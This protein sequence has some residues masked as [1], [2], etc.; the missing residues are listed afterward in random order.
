MS[1][2]A[3]G[4]ILYLGAFELPDK[5]AAAHRVIAN[6]KIFRN[7][8]YKVVLVGVD[9]SG[10]EAEG[11]QRSPSDYFEFESWNVPYPRSIKSW[12]GYITNSSIVKELV[13]GYYKGQ[14]KAVIHYNHPAVS[15]WRSLSFCTRNNIKHIADITEWYDS[16]AGRLIW[17]VIK[18]IDTALRMRWVNFIEDGLITTSPF[19]TE[20]YKRQ[21]TK[22]ELPALYDCSD[23]L[24]VGCNEAGKSLKLIYPSSPIDLEMI[25]KD[26]TNLK[27]RLDVIVES[28]YNLY[29]EGV[30][31]VLDVYG[32]TRDEFEQV[33]PSLKS[34]LEQLEGVVFFHGKI[35]NSLIRKKI[36]KADFMVFIRDDN[37]V[38]RAGF[39]GKLGE[40]ISLGTPVLTTKLPNLKSFEK[41]E[42]IRMS[43]RGSEVEMLREASKMSPNE[44]VELKR[45]CYESALFDYSSYVSEVESFCEKIGLEA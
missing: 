9:K 38:T 29:G 15:Q 18:K 2:C 19:V 35:E 20:Y 8:G 40:S 27:E 11:L 14:V 3:K 23:F 32:N 31:L 10:L 30:S 39:P 13:G 36:A 42:F 12:L 5:N 24:D 6:A 21:K 43:T 17:R 26:R 7:L 33:F 37:R 41:C 1:E 28:V 22:V 34:I 16:S 44:K 45:R 25:N 4:V